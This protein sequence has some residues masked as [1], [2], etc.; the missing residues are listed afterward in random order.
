[1]QPHTNER[2]DA[3]QDAASATHTRAN[4]AR[5]RALAAR[6]AAEQATTAFARRTHHRV[7]DRYGQVARSHEHFARTLYLAA[8][9]RRHD[10]AID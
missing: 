7:G 2:T 6:E 5:E 1:M 8:A 3:R 4:H 10:H 9:P